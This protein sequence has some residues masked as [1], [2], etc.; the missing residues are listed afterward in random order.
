M[1]SISLRPYQKEAI[2]T[3]TRAF[4]D[5]KERS[6]IK[7]ATGSGK[8]IVFVKMV[9]SFLEIYPDF[10][11]IF[12]VPKNILINQTIEKF[13]DPS[14]VGVYNA[15]LKRKELNKPITIASIQSLYRAKQLPEI[16][17]LVFDECH[18]AKKTHQLLYGRFKEIRPKMKCLG[19]TA[20]DY[21]ID[22]KFFEHKIFDIGLKELTK[23]GHLCKIVS[24]A[25]SETSK[26]DL[27]EVKIQAGDYVLS[28]LESK[29]DAE[30]IESQLKD[31]MVKASDRKK[32]IYLT[33]TIKHA[34]V[35]HSMLDN[36]SLVHSKMT[37]DER[38]EQ[39]SFFKEKGRHLVSVLIASEGFDYPPADCLALMRPTKSATLYEQAVG[40]IARNSPGK[41]DGLLLD[42]GNVIEN[43]GFVYDINPTDTKVEAKPKPCD[44]CSV[45]NKPTAKN[46]SECGEDFIT[47]CHQCLMPKLYGVQCCK[48]EVRELKN[49]LTKK[50][51]TQ[52]KQP[53]EVHEVKSVFIQKHT[54]KNGNP[55]IKFVYNTGVTYIVDY[56]PVIN[57]YFKNKAKD[58]ISEMGEYP[59]EVLVML[60]RFSTSYKHFVKRPPKVIEVEKKGKFNSVLKRDYGDE[61]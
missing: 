6:Y 10:K 40:R 4:R 31:V 51:Y 5:N 23:M 29:M 46:C 28:Q 39:M 32:I 59:Y 48:P 27:S 30:L 7:M 50:A 58:I 11:C 41:K 42:F 57:E 3:A 2:D 25:P 15:G 36:A 54:S 33:T 44:N 45:F 53:P 22:K 1:A 43:M 21:D 56:V 47:I 18:R 17:L 49:S 61:L 35:V 26:V 8:T 20:T 24:K 14:I 12:V 38:N 19:L 37:Q 52:K 13:K 55:C 60:N 16:N 34:Q 9:E